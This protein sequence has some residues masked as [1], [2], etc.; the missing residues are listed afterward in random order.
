MT[1]RYVISDKHS[2][3]ADA[4]ARRFPVAAEQ[5]YRCSAA[6]YDTFDWRLYHHGLSLASRCGDGGRILR[7][8]AAEETLEARLG[9][10]QVPGFVW[11]LPASPLRDALAPLIEMRRLLEVVDLNV[12]GQLLR[13]LD[14]EDKTVARV[15]IEQCTARAPGNDGDPIALPAALRIE[16]VKGYDKAARALDVFVNAELGLQSSSRG[17]MVSAATAVGR[18]PGDYSSKLALRLGSDRRTDEAT[19]IVLRVLL[20]NMRANED[21]VR[22]NTDSEFLH[23][24]RVA[25]R[26]TRSALAQMKRVFPA[27]AV[28]HFRAEFKWLGGVT[29]PVRDLDVYLLKLDDYREQLPAA[30]R[31]HLDPL[32]MFLHRHHKTERVRLVAA[33]RSARYRR[34]MRE[35]AEF[36]EGAEVDVDDVSCPN[37]ARPICDVASERIWRVY[38]GVCKRGGAIGPGTPGE[39]LHELRIECKKLRYLMEFFSSLYPSD[40]IRVLVKALKQLQENLGDFNDLEVQQGKLRGF[41]HEM[42]AEG[43]AGVDTLLAMG[44]LVEHLLQR[45]RRERRRFAKC[46]VRFRSPQNSERFRALF[47]GSARRET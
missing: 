43:L 4:I 20:A 47:A 21:G 32:G 45:Q 37:A 34:L 14:N 25:V 19:R 15:R 9:K 12:Q 39:A 35:W 1:L 40:Q 8:E 36:L 41:A 26:R 44:Q 16:P 18:H 24:F 3:T 17:E 29:G 2:D 11:E 13:V 22:A 33:L 46:F 28:A 38:R 42:S 7:L 10:G 31:G 27:P 6:Y 23:D 30:V 5:R